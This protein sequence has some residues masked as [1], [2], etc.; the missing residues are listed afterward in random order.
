MITLANP[1]LKIHAKEMKRLHDAV[2]LRKEKPDFNDGLFFMEQIDV[3][4]SSYDMIDNVLSQSKLVIPYLNGLLDVHQSQELTFNID[5]TLNQTNRLKVELNRIEKNMKDL[6]TRRNDRI[7][8]TLTIVATTFLPLTF[9]TGLFGMNFTDDGFLV[10]IYH[11]RNGS[12]AFFVI[13][14]ISLIVLF[15]WFNSEGFFNI[16]TTKE[17]NKHVGILKKQGD[18]YNSSSSNQPDTNANISDSNGY[19]VRETSLE[20]RRKSLLKRRSADKY[21]SGIRNPLL[22][23]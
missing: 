10:Y 2:F 23:V 19:R 8:L 22:S 21:S 6:I 11:A 9:L 5:R 1:V 16:L 14:M 7:N 18:A 12:A 3:F 13:A 15:Y 4:R 20:K 17:I